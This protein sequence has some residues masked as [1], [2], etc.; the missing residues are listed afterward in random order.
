MNGDP[1]LVT[2]L[3]LVERL[4]DRGDQENWRVF[5]DTYWKLIYGVALKSGL[6][7]DEAQDVVQETVITV[8]RNIDG[9][10]YDPSIGSFKGW[11]LQIARW[12]I[13]DQYRKR[14]PGGVPLGDDDSRGTAVIDR[15]ADP[16]GF[17]LEAIWEAEWKE[18]LLTAAMDRVKKKVDPKHYQIFDCYVIKGWSPRQVA[19][20]LRV[21]IAQVYLTRHRV[22]ALVRKEVELLER[23][24]V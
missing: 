23:S 7:D 3:S 19:D 4:A 8:S 1:F 11:L 21:N 20:A 18:N 24:A 5:F 12:R 2:R 6:S 13:I 14:K 15:V 17:D 10:K 22:G 9:L 16:E